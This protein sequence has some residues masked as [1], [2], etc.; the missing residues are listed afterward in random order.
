VVNCIFPISKKGY[1][2]KIRQLAST[3]STQI[4]KDAKGFF[5][6]GG[7]PILDFCNT[8]VIHENHQEDRLSHIRSAQFFFKLVFSTEPSLTNRQFSDL[9]KFRSCLRNY[10]SS[11]ITKTN[12]ST[13]TVALEKFLSQIK[14]TVDWDQTSKSFSQLS[15]FNNEKKFLQ[16]LVSN[17]FY[18]NNS[19]DPKR[20]KICANENCSHIFY[21]TTKNN[22]RVWCSMKSCGNIM[23]ARGFQARKRKG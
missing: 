8:F 5:L 18:L 13:A 4:N 1:E 16:P 19:A 21:D 15:I 10:F 12:S 23:K 17:F 3:K 7:Y 11:T 20:L 2:L 6:I 9:I 22:T 14:L